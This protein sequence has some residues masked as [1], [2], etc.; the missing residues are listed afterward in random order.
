MRIYRVPLF[1]SLLLLLVAGFSRIAPGVLFAQ[2]PSDPSGHWEGAI[3]APFGEI[4]IEIDLARDANGVLI[5][6]FS[7]QSLHGY[8]LT[9]VSAHDRVVSFEIKAT[10][11]GIFD[12]VLTEGG[13]TISGD[14]AATQG[15]APFSLVKKGDAR[16][17]K[18]VRSAAVAKA[19]EGLWN[20]AMEVEGTVLHVVLKVSNQGDAAVATFISVDE[21]LELPI[22]VITQH[23]SSLTLDVKSVGGTY[24]ATLN[25]EGTELTGTWKQRSLALPVTLRKAVN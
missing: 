24:S 10:S 2:A 8:P 17:E 21:G 25:S 19:F 4:P 15:S 5:G 23:D 14:F 6:A 9:N 22:A 1:V 13:T 3:S 20:G 11:G 16:I 18:P 7:N 12:G